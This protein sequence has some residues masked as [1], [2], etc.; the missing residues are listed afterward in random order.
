MSSSPEMKGSPETEI[1]QLKDNSVE[2]ALYIKLLQVLKQAPVD[3]QR[4]IHVLEHAI[5][6]LIPPY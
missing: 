4:K 2:L 6:D 1:R 5:K 3:N